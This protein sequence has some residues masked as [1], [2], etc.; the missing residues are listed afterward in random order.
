[1]RKKL[2]RLL[3]GIALIIAALV[4]LAVGAVGVS[5]S[6]SLGTQTTTEVLLLLLTTVV[7]FYAMLIGAGVIFGVIGVYFIARAYCRRRKK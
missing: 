4:F 5:Y 1:M 3:P 7:L 6:I 2:V